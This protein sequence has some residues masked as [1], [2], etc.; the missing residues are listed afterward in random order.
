MDTPDIAVTARARARL[1][2][3]LAENKVAR[4]VRIRVQPG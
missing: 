4:Y 2:A 1:L 3:H